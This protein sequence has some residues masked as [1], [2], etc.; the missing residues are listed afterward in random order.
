[1]DDAVESLKDDIKKEV[2]AY[3][4]G[5]LQRWVVYEVRY[6]LWTRRNYCVLKFSAF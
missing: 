6:L 4:T 1:M 3:I 2:D 5:T